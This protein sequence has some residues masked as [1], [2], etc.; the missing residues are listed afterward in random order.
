MTNYQLGKMIIEE[1][2]DL[3]FKHGYY[4]T[5][6]DCVGDDD[7]PVIVGIDHY[8][9]SFAVD[10]DSSMIMLPPFEVRS[11]NNEWPTTSYDLNEPHLIITITN[12]IIS[13]HTMLMD[14]A[15]RI[16]KIPPTF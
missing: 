13:Y 7:K 8:R 11:F 12:M 1:V 5:I 4:P 6:I 10:A 16:G 9:Y 15:V 14:S 3:L 2:I